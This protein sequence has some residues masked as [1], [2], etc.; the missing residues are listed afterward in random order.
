M[1]PHDCNEPLWVEWDDERD[2]AE[3]F[4]TCWRCRQEHD[5]A[6][7]KQEIFARADNFLLTATEL[8]RVLDDLGEHLPKNRFYTWKKDG[9]IRPRGWKHDGRITD[10]WIRSND[11]PVFAL[12]DVRNLMSRQDISA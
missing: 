6:K 2:Q 12:S 9:R 4:V 1:Q 5:V 3:L 8:L 11:P 7:L 10:Y